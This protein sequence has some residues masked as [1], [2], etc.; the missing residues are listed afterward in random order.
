[1]GLKDRQVRDLSDYG[2]FNLLTIKFEFYY[3]MAKGT[4]EDDRLKLDLWIKNL[5]YAGQ[6]VSTKHSDII[7]ACKSKINKHIETDSGED[8]K[9][10]I[11]GVWKLYKSETRSAVSLRNMC[12]KSTLF[13]PRENREN[14]NKRKTP[15]A[16]K[17]NLIPKE[18]KKSTDQK[19]TK[20]SA[21]CEMCTFGKSK[22]KTS[23]TKV[24]ISDEQ[25]REKRL[26]KQ[27]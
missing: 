16:Q 21:Q 3:N 12:G 23:H 2:T 7:E 13:G 18:K 26:K 24:Q 14:P 17:R 5:R 22:D 19:I 6:P 9:L 11:K 10:H 25:R 27:S 1:M 15:P 4:N 20:T 8:L